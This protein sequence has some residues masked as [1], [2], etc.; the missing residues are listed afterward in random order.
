[1]NRR[2]EFLSK[3]LGLPYDDCAVDHKKIRDN[4]NDILNADLTERR[5]YMKQKI[6]KTVMIAAALTTVFVTTALAASPAGMEVI[7]NVI[8]YFNSS[9]AYEV[10]SYE[11]LSAHNEE[12]GVSA[13]KDGYTLTLDNLATDD[14]FLHVFYTITADNGKISDEYYP[15]FDCRINGKLIDGNN[16]KEEGYLVDEGTFKGVLKLNVSSMEVPESF[17]FEMYSYA[18]YLIED[19]PIH[20]YL[21]NEYLDISD[22]DKSKMLYIS[23]TANKN[24]IK[25][26]SIVKEINKDIPKSSVHI[27]K[28]VISPFGNQIVLSTKPVEN[29]DEYESVLRS[30][31]N[32]ALFDD[33]GKSLDILNSGYSMNID[34]S[35]LNAF[36]FL[37]A[38]INTKKF[39]LIPVINI[40]QYDEPEM[41]TQ[42]IGKYPITF[43]ISDYGKIVITDIRIS[44]GR[45]EI[46]YYKD[47]FVRYDPAT[48]IL[49]DEGNNIE[50]L[51]SKL[52][53]MND[54]RVNYKDNS[55]T[56]CIYYDGIDEN[57]KRLPIPESAKAENLKKRFTTIGTFV[58]H[59]FKLDYDNAVEFELN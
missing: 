43:K 38:D 35:S 56:A 17:K 42:K 47:G 45:V 44:D 39:K 4:V 6:F 15:W 19:D 12:I 30:I 1:M 16:Q 24:S 26:E 53:W 50:G 11:A 59:S 25:Q 2:L 10:T 41:L 31:D 57:G 7:E 5:M 27:D 33:S 52:N 9:E 54:T 20:N 21:Y 3:E 58:D 8:S 29:K 18:D 49:D 48:I 40:P 34:G 14:N 46:D 13:S 28:I 22:E 32:F 37:K 23:I 51:E 36:E 55:Y